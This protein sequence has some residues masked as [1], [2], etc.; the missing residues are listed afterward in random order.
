MI[1]QLFKYIKIKYYS[2]SRIIIFLLI[3]CLSQFLPK[4]QKFRQ[5]IYS[6]ILISTNITLLRSFIYFL[7]RCYDAIFF[8]LNYFSLNHSSVILV[9]H[10]FCK[11]AKIPPNLF[12]FIFVFPALRFA[13]TGLPKLRYYV[14]FFTSRND[15]TT[16]D[17]PFT[18][19]L[20]QLPTST[21]A[22]HFYILFF[23]SSKNI[24]NCRRDFACTLAHLPT[25]DF[26][27]LTSDF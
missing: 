9:C 16:Q 24:N 6:I 27:L 26:R 4:K 22:Q 20:F 2:Q 14:A 1:L 13:Y 15:A 19:Y 8:N 23:T 7:L 5:T 10:N 12:I 18:F 25:S 17:K 3:F 21:S 11:K